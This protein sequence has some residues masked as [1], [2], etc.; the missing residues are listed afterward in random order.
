M[1]I[2]CITGWWPRPT[3]QFGLK[4]SLNRRPQYVR[5]ARLWGRVDARNV[6]KRV[7]PLE[8]GFLLGAVG[9]HSRHAGLNQHALRAVCWTVDVRRSPG[10]VANGVDD[11]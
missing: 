11:V 7:S 2:G 3:N 9:H 6:A 1:P 4:A 5:S 10:C 8:S